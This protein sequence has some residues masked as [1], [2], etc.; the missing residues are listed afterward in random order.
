MSNICISKQEKQELEKTINLIPEEDRK[1]A[2]IYWE[3]Y[4][5]V[6][7][8]AGQLHSDAYY[9]LP[10]TLAER[11]KPVVKQVLNN[12]DYFYFEDFLRHFCPELAKMYY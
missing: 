9:A 8:Y 1:E 2:I 11:A 3:G 6:Y 4:D 5:K 10:N 12:V 7:V